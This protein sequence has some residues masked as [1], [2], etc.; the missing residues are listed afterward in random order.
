MQ[1]IRLNVN[2]LFIIDNNLKANRAMLYYFFVNIFIVG[3]IFWKSTIAIY[4]WISY[5]RVNEIISQYFYF[6]N[7]IICDSSKISASNKIYSFCY[8]WKIMWQSLFAYLKKF[9]CANIRHLFWYVCLR[10]EIVFRRSLSSSLSHENTFW[11]VK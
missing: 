7:K 1:N 9:P 11:C 3:Y 5:L 8:I 4:G 6:Y 10:I 2:I